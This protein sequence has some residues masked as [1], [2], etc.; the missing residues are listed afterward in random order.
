MRRGCGAFPQTRPWRSCTRV[1]SLPLSHRVWD[2]HS[3][4]QTL[5]LEEF[6]F[7]A[8]RKLCGARGDVPADKPLQF[9]DVPRPFVVMQA[10][11]EFAGKWLRWCSETPAE[12]VEQIISYDRQIV[13]PASQWR[14][15][16][17]EHC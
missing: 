6:L 14:D 11:Q 8:R 1:A 2:A 15:V 17:G 9:T 13:K 10:L 7:K 12:V 16:E 5:G 3:A 4:V